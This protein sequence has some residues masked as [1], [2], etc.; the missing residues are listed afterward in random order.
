[1]NEIDT[2]RWIPEWFSEI[3][4]LEPNVREGVPSLN[5]H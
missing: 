3:L 4:H 2:A 1:M 5:R